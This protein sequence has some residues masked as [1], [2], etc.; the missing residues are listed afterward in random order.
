MKRVLKLTAILLALIFSLF[1][2]IFPQKEEDPLAES[3]EPTPLD[4]YEVR[5]GNIPYFTDDEKVTKSFEFYSDL[6]SL[7]R[8]GVAFACIGKDIMP[9]DGE[10]RGSI[11]SV[12][13]SGWVQASYDTDLVEGGYL[14]N[15][16][17]LIGWQ[18]TAE[19]ANSRNLITGTRYMNTEGMLPFENMVA[20]Y[21]K[22][23]ENH[24]MYRVT[25]DFKGTNAVAS[26]VLIEAFSVEDNGYGICFCVYV[27]N[28][29][30]GIVIN[31]ATGE[32]SLGDTELPQTDPITPPQTPPASDIASYILN[33]NSKK[34]HKPTC[35]GAASIKEENRQDY[36][37]TRQDLIDEGYSPCGTCKP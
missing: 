28:Y 25:P 10:D 2:C 5:N 8:C 37:G 19:N 14:Y 33:V 20:R 35:S 17:H 11:S 31:Y 22:E 34:F 23:T 4:A 24:V 13:P 32:S 9:K 26:G 16:A 3:Y 7:G 36:T 12:T 30:P 18:L 29:Q 1:G 27:F 21:I 15:R 6:D